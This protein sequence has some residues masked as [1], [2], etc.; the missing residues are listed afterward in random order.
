MGYS[1]LIRVSLAAFSELINKSKIFFRRLAKKAFVQ[2][3]VRI[4]A[5]QLARFS[6]MT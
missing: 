4:T 5:A 6:S 3:L 2:L 1:Q